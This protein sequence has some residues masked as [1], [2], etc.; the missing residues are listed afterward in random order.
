MLHKKIANQKNFS[1]NLLIEIRASVEKTIKTQPP[2]HYAAF[3]A[4]GTLWEFD[5]GEEFFQ[6]QI[7]NQLIEL[8]DHPLKHYKELREGPE[9][10][11]A[12]K[13]LAE[14]YT[15]HREED[16]R[17][18]N[19]SFVDSIRNDIPFFKS[20]IDLI[21]WLKSIQVVPVVVTASPKLAI[22]SAAQILGFE[23]KNVLGIETLVENGKL[24]NKVKE[25]ITW[26]DGKAKRFLEHTGNVHPIFAA[27]NTMG[28][29][30]LLELSLGMP[31]AVQS[32]AQGTELFET[33]SE[34]TQLAIARG[35]FTH[36]YL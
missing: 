14:V 24:T 27:G 13:W 5:L 28:D 8:P 7:D 30:S 21:Q 19:K 4:D 33:E 6:F 2:P 9:P 12:L 34:L 29:L 1:K 22:E 25:P 18:W 20:M 23:M 36:S 10:Q 15:T 31:L 26:R 3:D 11:K 17:Q 32:A 35:W 16:I